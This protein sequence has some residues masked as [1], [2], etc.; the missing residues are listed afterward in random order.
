MEPV[1]CQAGCLPLVWTPIL[2]G[3]EGYRGGE[4]ECVPGRE[5]KPEGG[6]VQGS[7]L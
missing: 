4:A 7:Q 5:I 6:G 1:L 3:G 2:E